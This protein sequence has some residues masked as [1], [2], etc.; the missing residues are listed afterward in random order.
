MEFIHNKSV[1]NSGI[2][3]RPDYRFEI[4]KLIVEFDGNQHYQNVDIIFRDQEKDRVYTEMGYRIIRIPYFIQMTEALLKNLFNQ[5]IH[6]NQEYPHGFIDDAAILPANFCELGI[7][8]FVA[9]L[10]RFPDYKSEIV[11]SL[12]QKI[13]EKKEINLV[14]PPSL[15]YLVA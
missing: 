7:K 9:D 14:L 10:D 13:F 11:D 8:R 12:R 5:Q 4:I 15:H 2:K 1:P 3:T 6:Y